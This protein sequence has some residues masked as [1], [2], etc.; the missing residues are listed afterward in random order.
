[1]KGKAFSGHLLLVGSISDQPETSST[2]LLNT[3][4]KVTEL[5]G[6]FFFFFFGRILGFCFERIMYRFLFLCFVLF[7]FFFSFIER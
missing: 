3:V 1:M 5:L 7:F 6:F 4:K 2:P